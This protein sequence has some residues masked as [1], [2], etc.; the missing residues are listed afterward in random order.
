MQNNNNQ[1][2]PSKGNYTSKSYN[3]IATQEPEQKP[4]YLSSLFK[5]P[6]DPREA[7]IERAKLHGRQPQN[8]NKYGSFKA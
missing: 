4:T 8:D 1:T 2:K 6:T 3:R 7:E 5:A